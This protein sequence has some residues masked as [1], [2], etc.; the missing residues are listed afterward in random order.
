MPSK[1]TQRTLDHCRRRGWHPAV[2]EKWIPQARRRSDLYGGID[3]VV[4][5]DQQGLLGI[6]ATD[7]S[8]V[9][10]RA[11]KLSALPLMIEWLRRGN[12][13]EIWGWRKLKKKRGGKAFVY[14]P[15]ILRARLDEPI[16]SAYEIAWD[17]VEQEVACAST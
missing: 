10:K 9:S 6:Q 7:G 15:R 2:V 12:R 1:P 8:S 16:G 14:R 4:M 5:D 13:L 11:E 17:V 3:L